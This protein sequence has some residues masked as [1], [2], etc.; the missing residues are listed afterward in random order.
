MSTI[1]PEGILS[2]PL[3]A[4]RRIIAGTL[5]F[6]AAVEADDVEAALERVFVITTPQAVVPTFCLV[7]LGDFAR[8]RAALTGNRQFQMR[9]PSSVVAYFAMPV[10]VGV[11]E[12]DACF[13]FTNWLGAIWEA[14]EKAAGDYSK[15]TLAVVSIEL[16]AAPTR[17]PAEKRDRA[18]D[19]YEAAISLTF[20]RRP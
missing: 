18:G 20:S 9:S 15:G 19:F 17:I 3:E 6:Q 13:A 14:I 16:V 10:A 2:A 4:A 7:D 5:P 11:E 1:A 8:D 12:P